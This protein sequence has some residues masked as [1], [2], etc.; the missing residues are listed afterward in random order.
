MLVVSTLDKISIRRQELKPL[1]HTNYTE[2]SLKQNNAVI[3][4]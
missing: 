2:Y 1:H 4:K 3:Y